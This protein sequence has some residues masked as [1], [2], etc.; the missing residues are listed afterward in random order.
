[1][2]DNQDWVGLRLSVRGQV[3]PPP[4]EAVVRRRPLHPVVRRAVQSGRDSSPSSDS[5]GHH[6]SHR[7]RNRD[8][9]HPVSGPCGFG[10]PLPDQV[11]ERR[12]GRLRRPGRQLLRPKRMGGRG[13]HASGHPGDSA[14][15]LGLGR[16]GHHRAHLASGGNLSRDYPLADRFDVHQSVITIDSSGSLLMV[17]SVTY[18]SI[19]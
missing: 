2:S 15:R 12:H 16:P 19:V 18:Y 1:M 8:N 14:D 9:P 11:P 3:H 17:H 4:A 7:H 6:R 5:G 13:G 10:H